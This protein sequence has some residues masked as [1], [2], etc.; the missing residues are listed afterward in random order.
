MPRNEFTIGKDEYL[1]SH[2]RKVRIGDVDAPFEIS[3]VD[4]KP[5]RIQLDNV[6]NGL[7]KSEPEKKLSLV[8]NTVDIASET[9]D[10][11]NFNGLGNQSWYISTGSNNTAQQSYIAHYSIDSDWYIGSLFGGLTTFQFKNTTGLNSFRIEAPV[12]TSDYFN[13]AVDTNAETTISTTDGNVGTNVAHLKFNVD[14]DIEMDSATGSITLKTDSG[15]YTPSSDYHIATKKY[16][17][18]NAGSDTM[19]SGFT[20]SATT[21]TNATTITQG[22]DLMFSAGTGITCETTADGTV[23][24]TNTVTNTNDDVSVANLDARLEELT[25]SLVTIG[26]AND[27]DI[28]FKGAIRVGQCATFETM[29][30][31]TSAIGMHA[32]TWGQ[33]NKLDLQLSSGNNQITFDTTHPNNRCNVTLKLKQP[34]SGSAGTVGTWGATGKTIKWAGGSP[35]TLSTAN[36]AEDILTF[37][38]DGTS[39]YGVGSLN[40]S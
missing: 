23:T 40:F 30:T 24:I 37:Y 4:F 16:V 8:G 35:P 27:V 19:G 10:R 3:D 21:D 38:Y 6:K 1:D 18:D 34:S 13:V 28:N 22:D 12:V 32:F 31:V 36:D 26:D 25:A 33:G 29:P 2:L 15:N 39:Y 5:N 11:L 20:V 9:G 7:V 14:G 17:D